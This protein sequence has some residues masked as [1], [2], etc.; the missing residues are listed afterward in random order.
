MTET[1]GVLGA[2][3]WGLALADYLS[4]QN[5][6]VLVWD[7]S[8]SVLDKLRSTRTVDRP[9]GL[10]VHLGILFVISFEEIAR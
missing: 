5:R 1:I 9:R 7:R 4:R 8:P 6:Q 2:G 3:A 10:V